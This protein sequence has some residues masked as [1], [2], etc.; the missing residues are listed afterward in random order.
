MCP[1]PCLLPEPVPV[2]M[3]VFVYVPVCVRARQ[4]MDFFAMERGIEP[5]ERVETERQALLSERGISHP[6][7]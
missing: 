2:S 7:F 5:T 4:S 3:S 6:G 1:C